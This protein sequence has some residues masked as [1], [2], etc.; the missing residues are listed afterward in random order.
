MD[1][2]LHVENAIV[3]TI[4]PLEK[5][6]LSE[7]RP[8][9]KYHQLS[10]TEAVSGEKDQL[11]VTFHAYKATGGYDIL[12]A[13][14][15]SNGNIVKV[16]HETAGMLPSVFHAPDGALWLSVTPYHPDKE[17]ETFLPVSGRD[18]VTPLKPGRPF[19]GKF[20]GTIGQQVLSWMDEVFSDKKPDKLLVLNFEN[21]QVKKKKEIKVD[22]PQRNK[23]IVAND[24]TYLLCRHAD[25]LLLRTMDT[26][27]KILSSAQLTLR[28]AQ[29]EFLS[30]SSN[31]TI[32]LFYTG[33]GG[34]AGICEI[35]ADGTMNSIPLLETGLDFYSTWPATA[36][37]NNSFLI[38]FTHEKGNGWILIR[39]QR[40]VECFLQ[41]KA[42]GLYTDLVSNAVIRVRNKAAVLADAAMQDNSVY[43][44]VFRPNSNEGGPGEIIIL[45]RS[46]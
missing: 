24:K 40:V 12:Y 43:A 18:N 41:N 45:Q 33:K 5:G 30:V 42:D 14:V 16:M 15:D 44:L 27:G 23:A 9:G 7:I 17:L 2:L 35:S 13:V 20:I 28:P 37:G 3:V 4:T 32:R 29:F 1:E 19:A 25:G 46:M 6:R 21:G 8:A 10:L 26:A 11:F 38:R 31:D 39:E 22:M 34:A 36:L